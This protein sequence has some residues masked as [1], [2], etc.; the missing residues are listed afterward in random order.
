MKKCVIGEVL[1]YSVQLLQSQSS[2]FRIAYVFSHLRSLVSYSFT[3]FKLKDV[4]S[5]LVTGGFFLAD[6]QGLI[7]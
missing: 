6:D 3:H 1:Q 5:L 4:K 2:E 7:L